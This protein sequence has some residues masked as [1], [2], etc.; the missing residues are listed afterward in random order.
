MT[1]KILSKLT[2]FTGN[3]FNPA[4]IRGRSIRLTVD[5]DG[6]TFICRLPELSLSATQPTIGAAYD[7]LRQQI[8]DADF[9]FLGTTDKEILSEIAAIQATEVFNRRVRKK[10]VFFLAISIA[11]VC[12]TIAVMPIFE[13]SK[14]KNFP[15]NMALRYIPE[16][17]DRLERIEPENR[18][19]IKQDITTIKEFFSD[20]LLEEDSV[21]T[22]N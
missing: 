9:A 7:G 19:N 5:T 3:L 13:V 2:A 1:T 12:L 21:Q 15:S 10:T 14:Y 4:G 17:A 6:E 11:F 8:R 20:V 16:I 22:N 18:Q